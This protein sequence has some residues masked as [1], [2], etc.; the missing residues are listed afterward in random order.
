MILENERERVM[1]SATSKKNNM[2]RYCSI[3]FVRMN[4]Q[5]KP[6]HSLAVERYGR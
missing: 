2:H 1:Q 5:N 6:F 3:K 4:E